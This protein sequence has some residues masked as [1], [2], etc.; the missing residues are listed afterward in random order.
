MTEAHDATP[1]VDRA[2]DPLV[3][4]VPRADLVERVE[5]TARGASVERT[6][7][8]TE[9]AADRSGEVGAGG[10]DDARREGRGVESVIDRGGHVGA[11]SV[12]VPRIRYPAGDHAEVVGDV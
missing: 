11:Q 3:D 1:G 9:G 4:P 8:G 6:S 12:L 2:G 10:G 5:G 7:E